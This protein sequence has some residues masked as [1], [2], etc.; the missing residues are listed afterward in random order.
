MPERDHYIPGVP[1]WVD[2]GHP[3]PEA[4]LDFYGGLFGWQFES[5]LPPESPGTYFMA[6]VRGGDV[7]AVGSIPAGAPP[8][9]GAG[10]RTVY[11]CDTALTTVERFPPCS[12]R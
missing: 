6:R 9:V 8:V 10:E 11:T 12:T 7:A 5:V 2:A 4:T 3:E 1:C